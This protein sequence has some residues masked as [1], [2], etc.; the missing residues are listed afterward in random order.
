[1]T[2]STKS[3]RRTASNEPPAN[4]DEVAGVGRLEADVPEAAGGGRGARGRDGRLRRVDADDLGDERREEEG[5]VAP[6]RAELEEAQSGVR[7]HGPQERRVPLAVL[8]RVPEEPVRPVHRGVVRVVV[9]LGVRGEV[10]ARRAS[11]G[12]DRTAR[13]GGRAAPSR[14]QRPGSGSGSGRSAR[15]AG[16]ARAPSRPSGRAGRARR[17]RSRGRSRIPAR[18]RSRRYSATRRTAM[19]CGNC[20][21]T[22][23]CAFIR[24]T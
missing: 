7:L 14:A 6:G 10:G 3:A 17:S 21:R 4:G 15:R 20:F 5:G 8:P 18:A 11:A 22:K 13:R 2:C 1:M 16:G 24:S 12:S 9:D 19:C 23:S